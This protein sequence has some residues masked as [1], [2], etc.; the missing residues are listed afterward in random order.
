MFLSIENIGKVK[1]AEIEIAGITVIAGENNTGKSTLGKALFSVF[2]CFNN[3]PSRIFGERRQSVYQVLRKL[4]YWDSRRENMI[5]NPAL[6]RSMSDDI[7]SNREA[8]Y[9]VSDIQIMLTNAISKSFSDFEELDK[10]IS[11]D[12]NIVARQIHE[13]LVIPDEELCN[14]VM[15]SDLNKEFNGQINNIYTD[16]PACIELTIKG[17]KTTIV[18]IDNKVESISDFFHLHTEAIYIDDP[19]ILDD[20]FMP[21]SHVQGHRN[22]IRRNIR[23]HLMPNSSLYDSES[24]SMQD[25]TQGSVK[26]NVLDSIIASEKLENIYA[27]IDKV[28]GGYIVRNDSIRDVGYAIADSDKILDVRNLSSGLKTFA[29]IKQFL[30]NGIIEENGTL[31]LD[32]PEIHLHP[33]WQI[34]FAELIVMLQREFGLHVLLNTHSPYFLNAVQVYAQKHGII[35]KCRYYQAV[36]EGDESTVTDVTDNTECIYEKLAAPFQALESEVFCV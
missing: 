5:F 12:I 2:N 20:A 15:N 9:S 28:C 30:L 22:W 26:D 10:S 19:F 16:N 7:V 25:E 11:E 18:I 33:A 21:S 32:E 17:D 13:R 35:E 1:K 4:Q 3:F 31:I 34:I 24:E 23:R 36:S 27:S 14:E 29:I 6:L 8:G